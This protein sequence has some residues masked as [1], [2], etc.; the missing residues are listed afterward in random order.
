MDKDVKKVK[1]KLNSYGIKIINEYEIEDSTE[2]V[3]YTEDMVLFVD[4]EKHSIGL[5]MQATT[6]PE[7]AASLAL[8][9]NET[10][11]EVMI[12][13]AFIFSKDNKYISGKDAYKL[14][15]ESKIAKITSEI[16]K[17]HLYTDLLEKSDCYE[18]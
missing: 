10:K 17:K 12:M 1:K 14:I 5:S 7:K 16:N 9:V 6:K 4:T 13:D 3:I 2:Y 18:C 8:I 11:L 15:S